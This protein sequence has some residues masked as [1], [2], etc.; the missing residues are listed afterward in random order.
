L[1]LYTVFF[2][3]IYFHMHMALLF[4]RNLLNR[5]TDISN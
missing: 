4:D 5:E 3:V 2:Y 1:V